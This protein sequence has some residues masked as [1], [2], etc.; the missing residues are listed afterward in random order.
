MAT[1]L[2]SWF[3]RSS[4]N[5]QAQPYDAVEAGEPPVKGSFPFAGNGPQV[6]GPRRALSQQQGVEQDKRLSRGSIGSSTDAAEA[7]NVPRRRRDT[8]AGDNPTATFSLTREGIG[9]GTCTPSPRKLSGFLRQ[10]YLDQPSANGPPDEPA[11]SARSDGG[12]VSIEH[13][14][15]D[16]AASQRARAPLQQLKRS[17][18]V[19]ILEAQIHGQRLDAHAS[20]ATGRGMHVYGED[21]VNRSISDLDHGGSPEQELPWNP[22]QH[23]LYNL[24]S[25]HDDGSVVTSG[26]ATNNNKNNRVNDTAASGTNDT[27]GRAGAA[28]DR[29]AEQACI[30]RR[31]DDDTVRE[32]ELSSYPNGHGATPRLRLRDDA[33]SIRSAISRDREVSSQRGARPSSIY[34]SAAIYSPSS[35]TNT[36]TPRAPATPAPLAAFI[37]SL[38]TR[39][40]SPTMRDTVRNVSNGSPRIARKSISSQSSPIAQRTS[41][42]DP[43]STSRATAEQR[44]RQVPTD[45]TLPTEKAYPPG[46]KQVFDKSLPTERAYPTERRLPTTPTSPRDS[47]ALSPATSLARSSLDKS[48]PPAPGGIP[49]YSRTKDADMSSGS[50]YRSPHPFGGADKR[51][52]LLVEGAKEAPSLEGIADLTNTEDSETTVQQLPRKLARLVVDFTQY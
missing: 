37:T 35:V 26:A 49:H 9:S 15:V 38:P 47:S 30:H 3:A 25:F 12:V 4:S 13:R 44:D 16:V 18:H 10:V 31:A 28:R 19:S 5:L 22:Q 29:A 45:R 24:D 33:C 50:T 14:E 36:A 8:H 7:P 39:S 52:N 34:S 40:P 21:A 17:S 32:T 42:D 48:L 41:I 1:R 23:G 43:A 51:P 2:R 46:G 11:A 27:R 20:S 6:L